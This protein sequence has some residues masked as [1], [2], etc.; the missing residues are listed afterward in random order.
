MDPTVYAGAVDACDLVDN[1]CDGAMD[2]DGIVD[3]YPDCDGDEFAAS[4][5]TPTSSC[6]EPAPSASGCAMGGSFTTRAPADAAN[7]DCNDDNPSVNPA[8]TMYQTTAI[9]GVDPS[10]DFDY[11]CSGAED[12]Q[13][14]TV[15]MCIPSGSFIRCRLVNAGGWS[16]AVPECGVAGATISACGGGSACVPVTAARTQAC[17]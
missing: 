10:I 12:P 4:G 6:I 8:Q 13:L 16:G 7:T 9:V 14:S 11:D 2:E 5:S 15:G 17:R 3:W 1:D